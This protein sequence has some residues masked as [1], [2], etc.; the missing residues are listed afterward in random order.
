MRNSS[1]TTEPVRQGHGHM[2]DELAALLRHRVATRFY[3][4]P[5]VV[6]AVARAIIAARAD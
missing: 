1:S 5:Q 3:D 6:D 4:Q 2:T